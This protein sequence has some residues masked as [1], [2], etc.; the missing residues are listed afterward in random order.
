MAAQTLN[1]RTV[2]K[3][4]AIV[5][6]VI[7]I[8]VTFYQ[9]FLDVDPEDYGFHATEVEARMK[10]C[11]GSFQQ[12]YDCKEA[13]IIAKGRESFL[14]WVKKTT[15]ILAPPLLL[16]F[17]LNRTG[18]GRPHRSVRSHLV[19]RPTVPLDKRRVR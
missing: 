14:V 19:R 8:S 17:L 10:G 18:R 3:S 4:T 9:E 7:W 11:G 5:A 12:R 1:T 15:L 13:I 6:S 2:L 16:A